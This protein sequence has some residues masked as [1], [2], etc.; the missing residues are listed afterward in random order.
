M[1]TVKRSGLPPITTT[2]PPR[3]IVKT[4]SIASGQRLRDI[5]TSV[6]PQH[7][8]PLFVTLTYPS[9]WPGDWQ[10]WKKHLNHFRQTLADVYPEHFTGGIWRLEAQRRGAPHFH[11]FLWL[12]FDIG[13]GELK[14]LRLWLSSVWY[15]IVGS[16]D[17][18]H[19]KA[20]TRIDYIGTEL[21]FHSRMGYLLKYLGKDSVHPES[22]VFKSPVGRYWGIWNKDRLLKTP[23]K[24]EVKKD[25]F[26]K[27]RRVL[28]KKRESVPR[29]QNK[30]FRE[31]K[32]VHK[33]I[34]GRKEFLS[35]ETSW[36]LLTLLDP[37]PF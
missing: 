34:R 15:R 13:K 23:E 7:G 17:E 6:D 28:R 36:K 37:P 21:E 18:K 4:F 22:Q 20:G 29:K 9:D 19:K 12:G 5:M 26:L 31:I 30:G 8:Y 14:N 2:P 3:S 27:A 33:E 35:S 32:K 11:V 1:M 10:I 16:G 25:V 24:I